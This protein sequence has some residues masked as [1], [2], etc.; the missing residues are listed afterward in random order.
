MTAPVTTYYDHPMLK[1]S[2]WSVDVPLYYF[3]G[4]AAGAA[5]TLG[6]ALQLAHRYEPHRKLH[7]LS[8]QCHWIGIAGSTAGA[9]LLIHDLGRPSR[10]V[11]ML[12]VFRPTSPMNMG[13]WILAGAAP[14]SIATGLLIGRRGLAGM[15][16]EIAGYISGVFGAALATYT[17]VLVANSVMP[18]WQEAGPWM[19]VLFSGSAAATAASVLEFLGESKDARRITR[20][21]GTA[22]RLAELGAAQR[23]ERLAS[24]VERVGAPF[25]QGIPGLLWKAAGVLTVAGLALSFLPGKRS[26]RI[27]GVVGAAGSL[28]LRFAVHYLSDASARDPEA[29]IEQQ[30]TL[31]ANVG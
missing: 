31:L 24:R 28:C 22:G 9:A 15:I 2:V 20:L 30:R 6:A 10:F 27:G 13:A 4:G 17:G 19:P 5:M 3:L 11:Y 7:R 1:R 25:R 18:I 12:R 26:R 14:G 21:F 29:V 16:G 8:V 23:V